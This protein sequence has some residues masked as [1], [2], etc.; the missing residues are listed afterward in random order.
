MTLEELLEKLK[1][2]KD[3]ELNMKDEV[4]IKIIRKEGCEDDEATDSD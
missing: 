2:M 1:K 3:Q 4:E